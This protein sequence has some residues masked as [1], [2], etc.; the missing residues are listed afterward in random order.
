MGISEIPFRSTH[1]ATPTEQSATP[2]QATAQQAIA[3]MPEEDR[4][5]NKEMKVLSVLALGMSNIA[6]AEQLY[7]SEST[8]R[9]HLRNINLKLHAKN[10]TEAVS[11]ARQMGLL[12]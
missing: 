9:T 10:R 4:L 11:I 7:V 3:A 12:G 2:I 6:I 5:T 8:V 1:N